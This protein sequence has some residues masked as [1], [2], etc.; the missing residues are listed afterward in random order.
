LIVEIGGRERLVWK[1]A[2]AGLMARP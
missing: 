2:I 1:H